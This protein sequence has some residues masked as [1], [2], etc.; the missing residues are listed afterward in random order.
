MLLP[1]VFVGLVPPVKRMGRLGVLQS[2]VFFATP[3]ADLGVR[4]KTKRPYRQDKDALKAMQAGADDYL[5]KL[6]PASR[7]TACE[8]SALFKSPHDIVYRSHQ[9]RKSDTL[10]R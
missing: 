9:H 6:K 8:Q 7:V 5:A 10:L 2:P 4:G 1:M 3:M